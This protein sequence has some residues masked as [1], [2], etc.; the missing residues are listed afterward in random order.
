MFYSVLRQNI[1][2]VFS[3]FRTFR[4][5]ELSEAIL[6]SEYEL[7]ERYVKFTLIFNILQKVD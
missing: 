5:F 3:K 1:V 2:I 4:I 7:N 6:M